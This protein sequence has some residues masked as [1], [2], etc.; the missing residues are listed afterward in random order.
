MDTDFNLG[1]YPR[2]EAPTRSQQFI[3]IFEE[4]KW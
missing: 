4:S 3:A 1:H 2:A